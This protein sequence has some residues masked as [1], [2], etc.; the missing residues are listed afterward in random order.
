MSPSRATVAY[1]WVPFDIDVSINLDDDEDGIPNDEDNCPD[2]ANADQADLDGDGIGDVCDPDIDGD[3][4]TNDV[5]CDDRNG[6]I[7]QLLTGFIDGDND[8]YGT[9]E[10]MDICSGDA[11]P[12]GYADVG[13]DNCPVDENA[14]QADTDEDGIGDAC[15]AGNDGEEEKG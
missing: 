7:Y 9:G 13:G 15:N 14:D 8:G 3:E 11:L 5:D 2:D 6:N 4:Y 10:A 1:A 12:S